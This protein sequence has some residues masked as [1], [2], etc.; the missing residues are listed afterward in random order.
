M[1]LTVTTTHQPATDIGFLVHKN[2]ARC[3]DFEMSFG[4]A[5]IFY[6]EASI[7]RCTVALLLDVDPVEM[8]RGKQG[9]RVSG[10][11]DQY[12]NDRPY[13]ASSFLSVAIAQL[14]GTALQ[15]KCAAKPDLVAQVMPLAAKIAVLPARGGDGI[16]HRMFEPLG[17]A[18]RARRHALD[19][20]FPDWGDS[21][22]YTVELEK[23]TTLRELL[24]HLYVL[25]PV[26]DNYKH[27]FVSE[28]EV[29]NLLKKGEGWLA[30]HPEREFITRR[31]LKFRPSL[32]REALARLAQEDAIPEE[33]EV[34]PVEVSAEVTPPEEEQRLDEA[35]LGSVLAA[36]KASGA[37]RVLDIGCGEG[38]LLRELLKDRQF[39]SILGMDVSIRALERASEKLHLDSM[40]GAQRERIRLIHG[41][42]MYRDSRLDGFDAAAVVE[43]VEHLDPPRL[44]AFERVLFECAKPATVVLTTPNREYNV[45]W[46][47]IGA[48]RFRH[49]DHRFEWTRSEFQEWAGRIAEHY[50]YRVRFLPIGPEDPEVG[51]PTQMGVFVR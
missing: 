15:G 14:F 21:P 23:N 49:A 38:R 17:Y 28:A 41:S 46:E 43:V 18:V 11:L 39:T 33:L 51:A 45:R 12:V 32:A 2:P 30:A 16:L 13:V 1:L 22:Y 35:R 37:K 31:Y 4:K 42:L 7:E 27:Y 34:N 20:K 3:Q 25:I 29:E 5:Y 26:L 40:P 9:S 24:T 10:L 8:V 6:P 48:D 50:K 36:L 44:R 19:D 47:N